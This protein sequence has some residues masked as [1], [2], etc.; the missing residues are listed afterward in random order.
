MCGATDAAQNSQ[1]KRMF[2]IFC[3][4]GRTMLF[5]IKNKEKV[6][7]GGTYFALCLFKSEI[8]N[9]EKNILTLHKT[10]QKT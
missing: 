3:Y 10:D 6:Y 1:N 9:Y 8:L 5:K 2:S 4:R 7:L